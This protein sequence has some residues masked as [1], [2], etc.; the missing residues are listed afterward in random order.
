MSYFKGHSKKTSWDVFRENLKLLREIGKSEN[1]SEEGASM[2][3][4]FVCRICKVPHDSSDKSREHLFSEC[5]PPDTLP[6]QA[7]QSDF[8]FKEETIRH[9][10]GG[11]QMSLSLSYCH[12]YL[13]VGETQMEDLSPCSAP[14]LLCQRQAGRW[15]FVG[16]QKGVCVCVC[17]LLLNTM[18]FTLHSHPFLTPLTS[19]FTLPRAQQ[20]ELH[21]TFNPSQLH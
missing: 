6:L 11:E 12:Y 20:H 13:Q 19:H 18:N 5:K 15:C 17:V 4:A 21:T 7:I 10:C 16:A 14:F 9:F 8:M 2:T 1:L 3:E